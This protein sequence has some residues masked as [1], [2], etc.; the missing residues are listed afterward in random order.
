MSLHHQSSLQEQHKPVSSFHKV[1]HRHKVMSVFLQTVWH[2]QGREAEAEA[3]PNHIVF[4]PERQQTNRNK[5]CE[6]CVFCF[7][8]LNKNSQ[9]SNWDGGVK[10]AVMR[11]ELIPLMRKCLAEPILNTC[12]C[13]SCTPPCKGVV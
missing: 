8:S 12:L 13:F 10:K 9:S 2:Q 1:T 4:N 11:F 6:A 5:T 3:T 7:H